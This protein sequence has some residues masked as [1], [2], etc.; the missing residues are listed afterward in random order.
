MWQER[1]L[2][3]KTSDLLGGEPVV[4]GD[5]DSKFMVASDEE[6]A[7]KECTADQLLADK[8]CGDAKVLIIDAAKMP[9]IAR[10]I[11]LAWSSGK[12]AMLHRDQSENRQP[13]YDVSCG[14]KRYRAASRTARARPSRTR[15]TATRESPSAKHSWWSSF[16]QVA[17]LTSDSKGW[18]WPRS[19]RAGCRALCLG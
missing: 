3:D 1:P 13:H 5:G 10:N 16:A 11:K 9:F 15:T 12:P 6:S 4:T 19:R 18:T 2:L 14:R 8:R 17:S 7:V